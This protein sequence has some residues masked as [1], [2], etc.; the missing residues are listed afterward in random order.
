MDPQER[1]RLRDI[2]R[3]RNGEKNL[4]ELNDEELDKALRLVVDINGRLTPTLAGILLIGKEERIRELV[5]TM[6][7]D[8]QVIEGTEVRVNQSFHEC[9]LSVLTKFEEYIKP[10]NPEH[11]ME[12]G[13]FRIPVPEFSERAFR[14]GVVNAFSHRDYSLLGSV[15]VE[16]TQE[17]LSITSPGGFIDGVNLK[18]LLTVE[19]HGRNPAL[20]DALKRIGLAEKTGRGIDR[21]YEGSIVYGRP[22]PDYS[23]STERNVRLYIPR[24]APDL[25]FSKMIADEQNKIGHSL[26]INWLLILSALKEEKRMSIFQISSSVNIPE[27]KVRVSLEQMLEHGLIEAYGNGRNR[28]YILGKRIYSDRNRGIEYVRQTD[29]EKVRYPELVIKLGNQQNGIVHKQDVVELLHI[30]PSQAYAVLKK[31]VAEGKLTSSGT[32]RYAYYK[33]V[34]AFDQMTPEEISHEAAEYNKSHPLKGKQATIV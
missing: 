8:F 21:I 20:A 33:V 16:I 7:A 14:E 24:S 32:G 11:E 34:K 23:E 31:L 10:W 4:L 1:R 22:L 5:P 26:S 29:I 30:T 12:Y 17:G 28:A 2:I 18:N 15:R 9:L 6:G 13:L 25:A 3:N 27:S 19:P